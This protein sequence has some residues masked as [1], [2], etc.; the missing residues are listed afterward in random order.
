MG[1]SYDAIVIGAGPAGDV[2]GGELAPGGGGTAT[3]QGRVGA[4][5]RPCSGC[6]PP[7]QLR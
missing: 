1:N 5:G 3:V 6:I 4:G 7:T 2:C